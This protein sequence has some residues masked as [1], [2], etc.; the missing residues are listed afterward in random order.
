[1]VAG[2]GGEGFR[3]GVGGEV[4]EGEMRREVLGYF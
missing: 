4:L 2:G 1:M 3:G